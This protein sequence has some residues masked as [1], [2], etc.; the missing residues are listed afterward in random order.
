M[1]SYQRDAVGY[2]Q[3]NLICGRTKDSQIDTYLFTQFNP[4]CQL[5]QIN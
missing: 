1:F 2:K 3:K 4:I 5:D